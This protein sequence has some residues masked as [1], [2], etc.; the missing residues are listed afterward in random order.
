MSG[1]NPDIEL[2]HYWSYDE[3]DI[4]HRFKLWS[5]WDLLN[6]VGEIF[7]QSKRKGKS[8]LPS[9]TYPDRINDLKLMKLFNQKKSQK[10]HK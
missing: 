6:R 9:Q 2:L 10:D 8:R 3:E 7:N 5:K 4:E 1:F